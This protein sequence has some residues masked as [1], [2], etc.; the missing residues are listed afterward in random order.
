MD[1]RIASLRSCAAKLQADHG[2]DHEALHL[3]DGCRDALMLAEELLESCGAGPARGYRDLCDRLAACGALSEDLAR[4][5]ECVFDVAERMPHAW[6]TLQP[7][8]LDLARRVGP[9]ALRELADILESRLGAPAQ[10]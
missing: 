4:R 1:P 6:S 9:G 10:P 2:G 3:A 8:Q 7:G 5:L